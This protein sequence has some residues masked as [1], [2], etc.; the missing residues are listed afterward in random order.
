MHAGGHKYPGHTKTLAHLTGV[1]DVSMMLVAP[2]LRM[3]HVTTHIGI[4]DAIRKIEP[5]SSGASSR[6][7]KR[8]LSRPV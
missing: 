7:A 5:G 1:D 4:I 2:K 3:I 6:A 8:R